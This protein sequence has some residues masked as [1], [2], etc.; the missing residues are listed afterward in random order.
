MYGYAR[1]PL[2]SNVEKYAYVP[3]GK[4]EFTRYLPLYSSRSPLAL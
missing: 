4:S 1:L 3:L 2:T